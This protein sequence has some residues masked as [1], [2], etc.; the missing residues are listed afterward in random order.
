MQNFPSYLHSCPPQTPRYIAAMTTRDLDSTMHTFRPPFW[1]RPAMAQTILASRKFRRKAAGQITSGAVS[2]ILDCGDGVRLKGSLTV[3]PKSK[4][5][6][7]YFHGW[8]G[9]EDSTYVL[10]SARFAY[11]RGYSIYRLNY[12]DHGDTHHLNEKL[13][14]SARLAEVE[15]ALRQVA[16]RFANQP[17]YLVGFSL[18]GN[19]A[20]RVVRSCRETPIS[21]LEHVFS[22]S[23]VIDPVASGPVIDKS[24]LI[25]RYFHKKWTTSM[26]KKQAA[27]PGVYDFSDV[28]KEKTVM[29]M[30][31]VFV[32][33]YSEFPSANAYF[34][35][36]GIRENDLAD[37][38]VRTSIVMS[39]DDPVLRAED[40]F[41]INLSSKVTRIMLDYGGHNG[42]FKSLH[43][44][45]WY[46]DYIGDC[47]EAE[48]T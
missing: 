13:F 12:R 15:N 6:F 3:H 11:E 29:G 16:D 19:F 5:L 28:L 31:D 7:F 44:P 4:G 26:A 27:F 9:S 33:A 21:N 20:L 35:A 36:Y 17:V 2:E 43:G 34:D 23:P 37:T 39:K 8:E 41:K 42:F 48:E 38:N 10:S 45:T 24:K 40:V 1:M 30:S 46:D 18:G 14:H 47:L 25:Q 32:K 22:I